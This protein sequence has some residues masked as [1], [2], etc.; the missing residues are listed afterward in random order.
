MPQVID[1]QYSL[2]YTGNMRSRAP[3]VILAHVTMVTTP[4]VCYVLT[5][6][7]AASIPVGVLL[8]I[9]IYLVICW[10]IDNR[11]DPLG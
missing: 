3:A 1:L 11:E 5:G 4:I 10:F 8:G 6:K 9:V 7:W 2:C